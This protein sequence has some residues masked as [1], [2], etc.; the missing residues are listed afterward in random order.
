MAISLD[1]AR[2]FISTALKDDPTTFD[3]LD[4]H[5]QFDEI[6]QE[7]A[8]DKTMVVEAYNQITSPPPTSDAEKLQ[9]LAQTEGF[10]N[11][12]ELVESYVFSSTV[13][14]ICMNDDCTY[15]SEYELDQ[16]SGWCEFCDT[17]TVCSGI[18]LFFRV[19]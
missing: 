12:E 10:N 4:C 15:T 18:E 5:D 14:G 8:I 2:D 11:A 7:L 17:T 13:P 9:L 6:A 19:V 1:G 3:G 16:W